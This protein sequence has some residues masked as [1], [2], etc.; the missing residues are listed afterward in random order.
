MIDN[1]NK[2]FPML[3]LISDLAKKSNLFITFHI[4]CPYNSNM[5]NNDLKNFIYYGRLDKINLRKLYC[6]VDFLILPSLIEN[7]PTV[8][9]E[10]ISC[11]TPAIAFNTGGVEEIVEHGHNGLIVNNYSPMDFLNSIIFLKNNLSFYKANCRESV[12]TKFS[13]DSAF[14]SYSN[15]YKFIIHDFNSDCC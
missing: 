9:I 14:D 10:C 13:Y 7:L 15:L 2:G 4:V 8:L 1:K 3:L 11:S 6:K 5:I 12:S